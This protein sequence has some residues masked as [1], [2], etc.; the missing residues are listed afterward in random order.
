MHD[1]YLFKANR[2]CVPNCSLRHSI[3]MEVHDGGLG[4]HFGRDKTL[5]L[6]EERFFWPKMLKDVVRHVEQCRICHIAKTHG[7]K[8]GLY[9]PLPVAHAPWEDVS[10]DFVM[11]LP[12]T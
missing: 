3:I 12:R 11:G 7:Q 5:A 1:G 10:L 2:L 6:V 8:T 4:S 9:T